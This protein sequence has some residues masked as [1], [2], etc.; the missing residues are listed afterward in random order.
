M[1]QL[2]YHEKK[3][4]KKTDFFNWK[5][6]NNLHELKV[7]RRYHLQDREDYTRYNKICG[8]KFPKLYSF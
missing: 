8:Y 5:K 1:R 2:K 6:E 4:L 3:L 7:I